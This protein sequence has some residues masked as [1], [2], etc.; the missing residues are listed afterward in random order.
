MP[1]TG[2]VTDPFRRKAPDGR[3]YFD[4]LDPPRGIVVVYQTAYAD[5]ALRQR[6]AVAPGI[7]S[8]ERA[9]WESTALRLERAIVTFERRLGELALRTAAVADASIRKHI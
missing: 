1:Y 2:P 6:Y 5:I 7:T 3:T 4:I 9:Y 8:I